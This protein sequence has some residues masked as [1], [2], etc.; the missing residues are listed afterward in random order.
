[1]SDGDLELLEMTTYLCWDPETE[2]KAGKKTF[3]DLAKRLG[4]PLNPKVSEHWI[5]L[6]LRL[7]FVPY[8]D[9]EVLTKHL[10]ERLRVRYLCGKFLHFFCLLNKK[11]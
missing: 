11:E 3:K 2:Q 5:Q 6:R 8:P 4:K 9:P 10:I 1:M 7:G